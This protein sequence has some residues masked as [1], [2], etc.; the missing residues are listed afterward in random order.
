M[1]GD[2]PSIAFIQNMTKTQ[3]P[4]RDREAECAAA[5]MAY[6]RACP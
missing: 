1:K 4:E 3:D 6:S 2:I 5:T